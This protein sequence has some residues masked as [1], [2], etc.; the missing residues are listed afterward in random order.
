MIFEEV[1]TVTPSLQNRGRSGRAREGREETR[2]SSL[3]EGILAT[4]LGLEEPDMALRCLL[5]V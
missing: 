5:R 4:G 2:S 1:T 3:D